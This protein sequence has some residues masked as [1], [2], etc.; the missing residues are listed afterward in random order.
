MNPFVAVAN[1][2]HLV[3]NLQPEIDNNLFGQGVVG[4]N[5]SNRKC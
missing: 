4:F 2:Y 1:Q 5:G 3:Q